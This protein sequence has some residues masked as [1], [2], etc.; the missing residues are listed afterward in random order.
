MQ[1]YV[2]WY[3]LLV[4]AQVRR[5]ETWLVLISMSILVILVAGVT[6]PDISNTTV[7]VF[8]QNENVQNEV[9]ECLEKKNSIFDF[10]IANSEQALKA[11]VHAGKVECGFVIEDD[12]KD[13][14]A[15]LQQENAVTYYGSSFSVKGEVAKETIYSALLEM[16][17]E[18]LLR[19]NA[20]ELYKD[21]D[22]TMLEELLKRQQEYINSNELFRIE[23]V[24]VGEKQETKRKETTTFPIQGTIALFIF[25]MVF[26]SIGEES[27]SQKASFSMCLDKQERTIFSFTH[28][29]SVVTLPFVAG[30]GM[31][32][33]LGVM[34]NIIYGILWLICLVGYSFVWCYFMR[35]FLR[36]AE[37][38]M[39][40]M[41]PVLFLNICLC[42]VYFDAST[43]FPV[44]S[45]I[46]FFLP[47]GMYL[48]GL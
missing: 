43:Y 23:E 14:F 42:P 38:F 33:F 11:E 40:W 13:R 9:M 16:M 2:K 1:K 27:H 12:I 10:K 18:I 35:N 8:C 45:V 7:L 25:F 31:M 37:R 32:L 15:N 22:E 17:S 29:L 46:R 19:K 21:V 30:L 26:L 28:C 39:S 20:Q 44:V 5:L 36:K 47:L 4:K 3:L 34:G 48:K 6:M 41:I 24:M